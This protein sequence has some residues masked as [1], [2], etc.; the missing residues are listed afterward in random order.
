[1]TRKKF[2][3]S[4]GATCRNWH[5]S[6]SFINQK[7]KTIIF[8][9][10]QHETNRRF[11]L[12]LREKWQYSPKGRKQTGYSQSREHIRLIEEKGYKLKIFTM[13]ISNENIFP[14]KIKHFIPELSEKKLIKRGKEWRAID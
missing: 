10:W 7:K 13:I 3:E 6:W 12:V 14:A 2:I 4:N 5:W 9:A 8:G 11:S 1:M